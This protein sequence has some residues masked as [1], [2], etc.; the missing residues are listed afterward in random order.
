LERADESPVCGS[1]TRGD[2]HVEGG[3]ELEVN[4]RKRVVHMQ[5]GIK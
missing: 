2:C 4:K 3:Q 5:K 1:L